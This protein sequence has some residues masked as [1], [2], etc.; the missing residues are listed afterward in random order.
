MTQDLVNYKTIDKKVIIEKK[1]E[2]DISIENE[3]LKII[4]SEN[5]LNV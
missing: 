4:K 5:T 2:M 3:K 1:E